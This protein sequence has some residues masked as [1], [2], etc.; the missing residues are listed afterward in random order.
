VETVAIVATEPM[1]GGTRL[2]WVAGGRVRRRLAEREALLAALRRTTGA[3]DPELVETVERRLRQAKAARAEAA[4]LR[5]RLAAR[6]AAALVASPEPV[7]AATLEDAETVGAVAAALAGGEGRGVFLLV[8]PDGGFAVA[9][10]AGA[11]GRAETLGAV[12]AEALGARG[13][14]R[15]RLYRGRA[16]RPEAL[17]AARAAVEGALASSG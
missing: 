3:G 2:H 7:V 9:L 11:P 4:R 15:D 14:G 13:G 6:I 16:E 10:G 8:A 5:E 17:E 1:H 12:A